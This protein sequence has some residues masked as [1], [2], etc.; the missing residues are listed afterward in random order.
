MARK[1]VTPTA[2]APCVTTDGFCGGRLRVHR[3]EARLWDNSA[4]APPRR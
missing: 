4:Q 1:R 3:A 2:A